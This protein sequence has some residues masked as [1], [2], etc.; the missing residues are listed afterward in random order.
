MVEWDDNMIQERDR[1]TGLYQRTWIMECIEASVCENTEIGIGIMDLDFFTNINTYIGYENGDLV[2][3]RIADS[4]PVKHNIKIARYGSDEFLFLFIGYS[5]LFIKEYLGQLKHLFRKSRFICIHPY[6]KVRIT[7]SMGAV[8]RKKMTGDAF[9]ILKT[10]EIA[11]A[12]AKKE[13]RNRIEYLSEKLLNIQNSEGRC[14]TLIGKSLKG[15]CEEGCVAYTASIAEPYGVE[16]DKNRDIL[17][18]DRS[19][20]QI[21]RI[22]NRRIYTVAGCG[23][24]GYFGDG[25]EPKG[26]KLCKPSGVCVDRLGRIYIADTGN[27]CIRKI[28]RGII[29]TVAGNGDCGYSGDGFDATY[30]T[31]NRPGGVTVDDNFNIYTN[32][33]GNNV[34]RKIDYKGIIT[35][36]AG[37][38][39]YGYKGDGKNAVCAAFNKIYGLYVDDS[40]GNLFIADYGNNCIRYVD[41]ETGIIRTLCGN[42]E[43]GYFGDDGPCCNAGLD[44]PYWVYYKNNSLYI[45]DTGNHCIRRIDLDTMIIST[46]VGGRGAGYVDHKKDMCKI[47]LHIP[48]G[49]AVDKDYL[50][51]ADYG[52]NAIRRFTLC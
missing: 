1:L 27:H 51:I 3:Q 29:S 42:G 37:N 31:L 36:I 14:M 48:A 41:L 17:F 44:S 35:T 47:K 39:E 7:F 8:I 52:N 34:V 24:E 25:G 2:L 10:A 23:K 19:N 13:G 22:H 6:E 43:K 21:K 15:A 12:K 18:V 50:I 49:I 26:A 46:V 40:G 5:E 30:A 45:A 16:I 4:F 20:H 11:L 28:E 32:D 33:Y 9:Q 38:G